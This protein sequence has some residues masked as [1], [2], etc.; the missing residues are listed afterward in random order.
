MIEAYIAA[1]VGA[2]QLGWS[3]ATGTQSLASGYWSSLT[4]AFTKVATLYVYVMIGNDIVSSIISPNLNISANP[5][6]GLQQALTVF[7]AA[8]GYMILVSGGAMMTALNLTSR[9]HAPHMH[10]PHGH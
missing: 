9:M 2:V 1:T 3:A 6:S 8:L 10:F 4:Q 5:N 7:A